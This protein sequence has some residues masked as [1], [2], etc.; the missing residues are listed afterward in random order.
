VFSNNQSENSTVLIVD[1]DPAILLILEE[2]LKSI[3]DVICAENG[4]QALL[5]AIEHRPAVVLLD[6]EM[7]NMDGFEVC[8]RLKSNPLTAH[9]SVIFVTSHNE[10]KFESQ[11]LEVGGID[12][13]QKPVDMNICRLRVKNHLLIKN[14]ESLLKSAQ[15]DLH[16]LVSIVPVHI[17]YWS[18]DLINLF[19]ND[20]SGKWF[21][22]SSEQSIGRGAEDILPREI[23]LLLLRYIH[24][25]E[26]DHV[27]DV[28][29]KQNLN[30]IEYVQVHIN[31]NKDESGVTGVILTLSDMTYIKLAKKSLIT[32]KERLRVIL[33][34]IGDAVIATDEK[35]CVT[36]MNPIAERMTGWILLE[37]EGQPIEDVMDLCDATTK[38]KSPNPIQIALREQR[39][40]TMT[41]NCELTSR[42]GRARRIEDSA[43]PIK[44]DEGIIIGGIIVFH[45]VSESVAMAVK[46]SHLANHDQ[47]TDLPNR[48]L[49]HDRVSQACKSSFTSS[50]KV[51]LLLVDIDHFKYINDSMGHHIGDLIIKQV[52]LRLESMVEP[53][54]TL[55]RI[56]GDE[57]V[58]LLSHVTSSSFIDSLASNIV[59]TINQPF[60]IAGNEYALTVSL[61][62]SVN[63]TDSHSAEEMMTHADTAMYKAKEQ[64]RNQFCYFSDDLELQ[65]RQR[66][67][68]EKLLRSSI[69]KDTVEVFYQPKLELTSQKLVGAEALVRLRDEL[70]KV[71]SPL[72]FIALAEETGLIHAMGN[73]V[74]KQ[75]CLAAKKWIDMGFPLKVAVN[76][77]AKQFS[78]PQFCQSVA[79]IIQDTGLPSHL[80]E[81]EVTESALMYD[82]E[83]T[84][85]ILTQLSALGLSI[86]IDDFGTGYSSLSYLKSFPVDVLKIDQSFVRDMINDNQSQDIVRAIVYLAHSL[87]LKL[88]GEGIETQEHL[89][90]LIELGC[91]EGQGYLFDRPMPE[92]DFEQLLSAHK[93]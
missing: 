11:S 22:N 68:I 30:G 32:E 79:Q 1:D 86:A 71:V 55:A 40:V 34:S 56:G 57:F 44:D 14:Q 6:I 45:D 47:L 73:C 38:R 88:V 9:S 77:S 54:T 58:I 74:L 67:S 52:A 78:D 15:Q 72:D 81:L 89:A 36:F 35:G 70:G 48:I 91:E 37:A 5:K 8:R 24:H 16:T 31:V 60:I 46:M 19:N 50:T 76:I 2:S 3:A 80:L 62:I 51:A 69:E 59:H 13:I 87:K 83:E 49:L 84:K 39:V 23:Y 90:M 53:N 33:N 25:P 61:G 21:G 43:V 66:Q 41:L 29:L 82:F 85:K 10:S 27:F 64:G 65:L 28:I 93:T 7:P 26:T 17:S 4:E 92:Q 75:S 12:F 42:D 20:F 18:K 63:P